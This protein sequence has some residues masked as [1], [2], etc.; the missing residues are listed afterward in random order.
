MIIYGLWCRIFITS[1]TKP[2]TAESTD[3]YLFLI[4]SLFSMFVN[5]KQEK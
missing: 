3:I 5:S 4:I 2:S 1:G